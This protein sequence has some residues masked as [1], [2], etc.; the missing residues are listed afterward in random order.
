[1]YL[2]KTSLLHP[3]SQIPKAPIQR[4]E[5]RVHVGGDK[6]GGSKGIIRF[7]GQRMK[8]RAEGSARKSRTERQ[9]RI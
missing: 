6:A 5:G 7:T 8:S 4:E 3:I 2:E 1:M 9:S